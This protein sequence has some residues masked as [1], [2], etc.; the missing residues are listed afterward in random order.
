MDQSNLPNSD[1]T[2]LLLNEI[3]ILGAQTRLMELYL[4][5]AQATAVNH[6]NRSEQQH[7]AELAALRAVLAEK[8][9]NL[10]QLEASLF[11]DRHLSE[12]V[13]K[14]EAELADRQRIS[15]NR[16]ADLTAARNDVAALRDRINDLE[17]ARQRAQA[18]AASADE[19]SK[20]L[21]TELSGLR[22]ELET[23][24]R[25]FDDQL[26]SSRQ[27]E[28][29][30]RAQLQQ[31]Q[32]QLNEKQLWSEH[33]DSELAT[34]QSEIFALQQRID[35]LHASRQQLESDAAGELEKSRAHFEAEIAEL[36]TT[37][38]TRT[39]ERQQSQAAIGEIESRLNSEIIGLRDQ[40]EKKQLELTGRDNDWRQAKADIVDLRQQVID[41]QAKA[42]Q[43]ESRNAEFVALR[44]TFENEIAEL[45]H[46]VGVKERELIQRYEAVSA[47]ELALHSRIQVL[48]QELGHSRQEL[49]VGQS[50]LENQRAEIVALKDK[51]AELEN[52][53]AE[54]ESAGKRLVDETRQRVEAELNRL[55][56]NLAQKE[57]SLKEQENAH[58]NL[59]EQSNTEIL[60]LRQQLDQEQTRLQ[61]TN[62]ELVRLREELAAQQE[63]NGELDKSRQEALDNWQRAGVIQS[64]LQSRL[65]SK[66]NELDATHAR[67]IEL[68]A[69]LEN[70][71][72]ELNSELARRQ[73]V[74][75]SQ[76]GEIAELMSQSRQLL[77]QIS[78]LEAMQRQTAQRIEESEQNRA[79]HQAELAKLHAIYQTKLAALEDE[80]ALARQAA[81]SAAQT[82][83]DE[84][85]VSLET[86]INDLQLEMAEKQSLVDNRSAEIIDLKTNLQRSTTQLAELEPIRRQLTELECQAEQSRAAHEAELAK[87]HDD[88]QTNL[89]KLD[90]ELAQ[91]RQ[92]ALNAA[93]ANADELRVRDSKTDELQRELAQKQ[94]LVDSR[95]TEVADLQAN[96]QQSLA[97]LAELAQARQQVAALT[98]ATEQRRAAHQAE[99]ANLN[100]THGEKFS[101]LEREIM[102]A[103]E[104][105]FELEN[106]IQEI[107]TRNRQLATDLQA[108]HQHMEAAVAENAALHDRLRELEGQRDD[109]RLQV[110]GLE[111]ARI[112]LEAELAGLR[113]ELQ[114]KNW[115]LAQQHAAV[116]NLALV[117]KEQLQKLESRLA[118]QQSH[119]SVRETE[120]AQLQVQESSLHQR[121]EELEG[122]LRHAQLTEVDRIEQLRR[123]NLARVDELNAR[124]NQKNREIE[125]RSTAQLDLEQALRREVER[126]LHEID[127][128]NGILQN[129]NDELVRV[130]ADLDSTNEQ[131]RQ[132]EAAAAQ[133]Q[134]NASG[135]VEV[136]RT[137]YQAQLALLQ[138][139]LSQ[140]EWALEERQASATGAEHKYRQQI[141]SL[142]QQLSEKESPEHQLPRDFVMGDDQLPTS[143]HAGMATAK[144]TR[145][146]NGTHR[147]SAST[148]SRDRRWHSML[149]GKRRWKT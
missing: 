52:A 92:A 18:A 67:G 147:Q 16:Q 139:E 98:Q 47:V 106:Q 41:L 103:R 119:G 36:Q 30:L 32:S 10:S 130:K 62:T 99:L 116:E 122:E 19:Q 28:T 88:Y 12:R 84:L 93:Q 40:L 14:L 79:A 26:L 8:E 111:R 33:A 102:P 126:L 76:G 120:F 110:Q 25:D 74:I 127:E 4:K 148:D 140:K 82:G 34:A 72:A 29:S 123:E 112:A 135:E 7:Q 45:E 15:D 38:S 94:S 91:V 137:Q 56:A 141:A 23:N 37:L 113:Q 58:R 143:E 75:D 136:M 63:R 48:Q 17:S 71:L 104:R 5:Q 39:I 90:S 138:A 85:R 124:V 46:E 117:H 11:A 146:S 144:P 131:H 77:D 107:A 69:Q 97:Q 61:S 20:Q 65:Q 118:E 109:Q 125:Q 31:L 149:G 73:S 13:Q 59:A 145:D 66:N 22:Q 78:E 83:T 24:R 101:A 44:Q 95:S 70:K 60:R 6:A 3:E 64:E 108:R 49:A 27:A 53:G 100:L 96:L 142:R 132:L 133:A 55:H 9:Q 43:A 21:Q 57:S 134:S 128:R 89:A 68:R 80:L 42:A 51:I 86:K 2:I 1:P 35:E 87:F 114:Q 54:A 50:E 81:A 115:S 105:V 121:V 129:R